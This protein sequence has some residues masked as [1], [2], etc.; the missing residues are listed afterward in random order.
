LGT[1]AVYLGSFLSFRAHPQ[2]ERCV[3]E[4]QTEDTRRGGVEE[5]EREADSGTEGEGDDV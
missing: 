5:R 1:L 2:R 3:V 4:R